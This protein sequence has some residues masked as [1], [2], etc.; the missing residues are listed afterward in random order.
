[1]DYLNSYIKSEKEVNENNIIVINKKINKC[2]YE[3]DKIEKNVIEYTKNI[4]TTYEIFS[5]NAYDKD[6]NVVEIE[7]LNLKKT[8]LQHEI[9]QLNL[10]KKELIEHQKK[11]DLAYDELEEMRKH[12]EADKNYYQNALKKEAQKAEARYANVMTN[13]LEYQIEKDNHFIG[14]KIISQL[15]TIENKLS[16]CENFVD[17][18]INRAK[19]Q[20]MR[21]GEEL[22]YFR[23]RLNSKMFHVKHFDDNSYVEL[24]TELKNFINLYKK[25]INARMEYQYNGRNIIEQKNH[26]INVMRIIMEAIDNADDHSQCNMINISVDVVENNDGHIKDMSDIFFEANDNDSLNQHEN[27]VIDSEFTN[28]ACESNS[29]DMH[30][31]NFVINEEKNNYTISVKISDNGTGFYM[32]EIDLLIKNGLYGIFMMKY[33]AEQLKGIFNINSEK[34]LGTTVTVVYTI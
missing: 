1:M 29:A 26:V 15:E 17:M 16:L 31:I 27:E 11:I 19:L 33:R 7:K 9:E 32:Q 10:Q 12:N 5:P 8:Q 4:D 2:L 14:E 18:D 13:L 23:K 6:Y 25:N 20:L 3:I 22:I 28:N 30:Q 21:V 34:G 24:N